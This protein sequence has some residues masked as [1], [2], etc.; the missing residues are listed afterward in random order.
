MFIMLWQSKFVYIKIYKCS[1]WVL[2]LPSV[3]ELYAVDAVSTSFV[4]LC[5]I[6]LFLVIVH[7]VVS[8]LK[9]HS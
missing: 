8:Y 3:C 4:F 2:E 1:N 5:F 9:E 6:I 7:F